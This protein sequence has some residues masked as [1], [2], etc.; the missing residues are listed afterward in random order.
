MFQGSVSAAN[1]QPTMNF[2]KC[3]NGNC[4][5]IQKK[6][7]IKIKEHYVKYKLK[8]SYVEKH[9]VLSR[10]PVRLLSS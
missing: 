2:K 8:F 6:L 4:K 1:L 9:P 3:K 5:Y 10:R 7:T